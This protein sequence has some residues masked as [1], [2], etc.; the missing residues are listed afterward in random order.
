MQK[1]ISQ[2]NGNP[3][4]FSLSLFVEW[5]PTE[6]TGEMFLIWLFRRPLFLSIWNSLLALLAGHSI[7]CSEPACSIVSL[8]FPLAALPQALVP[9]ISRGLFF[10]L[11]SSSPPLSSP[12]H[13]EKI[14]RWMVFAGGI[15]WPFI[16]GFK[17]KEEGMG[18]LHVA[19]TPWGPFVFLPEFLFVPIWFGGVLKSEVCSWF[20]TFV[21]CL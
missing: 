6:W 13:P 4:V 5:E 12:L 11:H 10:F 20:N 17:S 2:G 15:W 3:V 21:L 18:N 16:S 8:H 14:Q 1:H 7:R 19:T 9:V